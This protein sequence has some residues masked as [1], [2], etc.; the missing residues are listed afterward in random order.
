MLAGQKASSKRPSCGLLATFVLA[1]VPA[2]LAA[3]DGIGSLVERLAADNAGPCR[4]RV[5]GAV[6]N[7]SPLV[8]FVDVFGVRFSPLA[9]AVGVT[10]P[11]PAIEA[12]PELRSRPESL[13]R[14]PLPA[15]G[16]PFAGIS[17]RVEAP[18]FRVR[19]SPGKLAQGLH[20]FSTALMPPP[21]TVPTSPRRRP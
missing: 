13:E 9:S 17:H 11:A 14:E 3:D 2:T 5:L 10:T 6:L 16:T 21:S 7:P 15:G 1:P 19:L 4:Q 8:V 18:G 12:A 20:V